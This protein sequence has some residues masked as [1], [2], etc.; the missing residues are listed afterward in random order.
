[1]AFEELVTGGQEK[2]SLQERLAALATEIAAAA[3]A[4]DFERVGALSQ[5]A[6][7]LQTQSDAE[8]IPEAGENPMEGS[9]DAGPTA[10]EIEARNV[11]DQEQR[12]GEL[13]QADNLAE[14]IKKG[15]G[16]E[17]GNEKAFEG[18][19]NLMK[20]LIK[21][22]S[23]FPDT[24]W[25]N[26]VYNETVAAEKALN[27]I[28]EE[29]QRSLAEEIFNGMDHLNQEDAQGKVMVMQIFGKS[30]PFGV[31]LRELDNARREKSGYHPITV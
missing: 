12:Q 29:G 26:Q 7:E 18:A 21:K 8:Q 3:Q 23:K 20:D 28:G 24:T 31:R 15:E 9:V 14:L 10:E 25:L 4:G 16:N 1:M 17:G 6:Q 27:A 5:Q 11:A 30:S 19:K 13:K 22:V 2:Q